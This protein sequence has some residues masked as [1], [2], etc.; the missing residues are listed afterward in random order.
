MNP[1]ITVLKVT[2]A[3]IFFVCLVLPIRGFADVK[4]ESVT[5]P[6]DGITMQGYLLYDDSITGKRPGVIVVHE[7]WGLNEYARDRAKQLAELGY[8]ALAIDMYGDGKTADHPNTAR[9]FSKSVTKDPDGSKRRFEAALRVLRKHPSVD[10]KRIA[11]IG[12]CFGG[13]T[14]L[15]M[16]RSG[17]A[18]KGVVSFHG[19]LVPYSED[20]VAKPGSVKTKILVCNGADDKFIKKEVIAEF[21]KEMEA[22]G[23]DYQFKSYSNAKHSFTNP[24]ANAAAKKFDI[25]IGY[26]KQADK[27]SWKDMKQFLQSVFSLN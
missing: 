27:Q 11:A 10:A 6:A 14:V 26:N 5:Y 8:T 24:Y 2:F 22:A 19:S 9:E 3:T 4:E 16:A 12:Y 20:S 18:L 17:V 1:L 23:V 7:W 13:G 21:K 25:D 15:H